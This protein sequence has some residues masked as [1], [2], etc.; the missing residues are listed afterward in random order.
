MTEDFKNIPGLAAGPK[1]EGSV[2]THAD[3]VPLLDDLA[4]KVVVVSKL[5]AA[6]TVPSTV[7]PISL[8]SGNVLFR[9][10]AVSRHR[11]GADPVRKTLS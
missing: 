11:C 5:L 2:V 4:I 6:M 3:R 9:T 10:P 7:S 1:P 8:Q